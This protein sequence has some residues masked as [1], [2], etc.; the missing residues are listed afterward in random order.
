MGKRLSDTELIAR[1]R[2]NNRRRAERQRERLERS[3]QSALMVWVPTDL[4]QSLT[5]RAA[6]EGVTVSEMTT[7]FL[8][9]SFFTIPNAP[10]ADSVGRLEDRPPDVEKLPSVELVGQ[11]SQG[12]AAPSN[13]L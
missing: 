12:L 2:E 3:G 4:K 10:L 11:G 6:Q 1:V 13:P 9:Q 8:R 5:E 7:N